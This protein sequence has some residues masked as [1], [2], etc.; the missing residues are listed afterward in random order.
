MKSISN[1]FVVMAGLLF[2]LPAAVTAMPK[3][4]IVMETTETTVYQKMV[5]DEIT[6]LMAG[7]GGVAF[8]EKTVDPRH[9]DKGVALLSRLMADN[10]IDCVI[11]MGALV[12]DMLIRMKQY[13][14]PAIATVVVDRKLQGLPLTSEDTS[15]IR[16]FN[17]I[18]SG[19]DVTKDLQ[20][21][22]TLYDFHHLA[23]VLPAIKTPMFHT[24]YSYF[25]RALQQVSPD[26]AFSLVEIDPGSV[27]DG[28]PEIPADVDAVYLLP[29]FSETESLQ[30]TAV[31]QAVNHRKLPSFAMMGE[32]HVRMGAMA[33]I[34]SGR[35]LDIMARRVA[36]NVLDILEGRDAGTLSVTASA[37]TDNFVI[38]M[39]TLQ[40]ID[41]YPG[42]AAMADARLLNLDK[43]QQG[44]SLQL[45]EVILE[46]LERNLDLLTAG[47][48]VR[49]QEAETGK[50]KG[51]LLPQVTLSAGMTHIDEN[52]VDNTLNYPA[53]T[54]LTG[55]AGLSQAVFSDD[56]LANHAI[57][58]ILTQS[59]RFQ[60][61][62]VLLDTVVTAA[63]AYIDLLF[64]MSN[65]AIQNSNLEATR[66]NLEIARNKSALGAVDASEVSRWESEKAANQIRL[67]DAYR[68]HQ[69]ARMR[70][71]QVL[72]RPINRRF[73]VSDIG[74]VKGIELMITDPDVYR[75]LEN[76]KQAQRFSDFLI[77]EADRNMPELKQ[78]REQI[79]SQERQVLNRK[80][81][82]ILP[83]IVLQGSVDKI[84][85]ERDARQT[86]PSDLDHP[87]SVSLMASWPVFTGGSLK[88]DL[89]QSRYQLER[90]VLEER[91]LKNQIHLNVRSSLETAAV[92]AREITLADNRLA[93]A[94]K[95][96][97][98]VQ[99]GYAQGRNSVTDL[100]DA[101]N[102]RVS[103]E[104][105][106]A[107]A[108]Y[109]F[110]IDFL[111]M[112]RATGRFY[113]LE[114]PEEK[115]A[116]LHRLK[117]HLETTPDH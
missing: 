23:V 24:L 13:P 80:R 57:Q 22:R 26:A 1:V 77:T 47:T 72:D 16:N 25:G 114:S 93:A 79:R 40:A 73:S 116:F 70:L 67:N 36:I 8:L 108:K 43:L 65:Q 52:R 27:E 17:Y 56:L 9:P 39:E 110:V 78:V 6:T 112:E 49:I 31:I 3:V 38:N 5:M 33:S 63:Y 86:T 97:D 115:Q 62:A 99:A 76:I 100:I 85:D 88:K 44:V 69:L 2:F 82:L 30:I 87:W 46:A 41:Y 90:L 105:D 106:A 104:R 15:G 45:K 12:S 18:Q 71:N 37:Y 81:A 75:L 74:P 117:S 89:A 98:I 58:T 54:T 64:A 84:L 61:K 14:G 55:S 60:E 32:T 95:S 10:A 92:S 35:N 113:F 21:F 111:E 96:Y 68:D 53:R 102:A 20:T 91:N 4:A 101:Q 66:K 107:S 94:R 48:D 42:S 103:S 11:G 29:L 51:A 83:D 28:I 34:A 109:Q 50:A 7:R 19:F 59:V